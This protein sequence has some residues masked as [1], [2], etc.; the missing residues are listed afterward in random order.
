[1]VVKRKLIF[2][3]IEFRS[4]VRGALAGANWK[5]VPTETSIS[6]RTH[7]WWALEKRKHARSLEGLLGIK[8]HR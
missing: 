4:E 2:V 3:H 5:S 6:N 1:V 8:R 7:D